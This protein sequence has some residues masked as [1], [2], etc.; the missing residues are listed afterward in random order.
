[1]LINQIPI[2]GICLGMQLMLSKSDEGN[3][4]GLSW[5]DGV[6]KKFSDQ[7]LAVPH[8]GW[9]TVSIEK[10]SSLF[11]NFE[12]VKR[13]Y[14]VHSYYVSLY[15]KN[16]VLTTTQYGNKFVSSFEKKNIIGVQFHPEK[17]HLYGMKLLQNFIENF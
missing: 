16:D 10:D 8:M 12:S 17:S 14:F 11:F 4:E 13:F 3:L 5:V 1:M 2:F 6:S 7:E 9:N 15:N